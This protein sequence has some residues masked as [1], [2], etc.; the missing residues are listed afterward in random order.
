MLFNIN[1]TNVCVSY[2]Y[3]KIFAENEK[4]SRMKNYS[5]KCLGVRVMH[6]LIIE[7]YSRCVGVQEH[8]IWQ[9][10]MSYTL[11]GLTVKC[12][13]KPHIQGTAR[14]VVFYRENNLTQQFRYFESCNCLS[15]LFVNCSYG[16]HNTS[17]FLYCS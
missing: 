4:F 17:C 6:R 11:L 14:F 16:R 5:Q 7:G 2:L 13:Q 8:N 15:V 12:W 10:R 3:V 9:F 1:I